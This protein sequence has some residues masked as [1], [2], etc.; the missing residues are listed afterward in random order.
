MKRTLRL[1]RENLAPLSND[2]LTGVLGA[3][4][5]MLSRQD[6]KCTLDNTYQV[7]TVNCPTHGGTCWC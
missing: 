5:A 7:C 2:D 4:A 3:A 6:T 1:K